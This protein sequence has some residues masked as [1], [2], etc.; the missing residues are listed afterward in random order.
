MKSGSDDRGP[1]ERM[2]RAVGII[3]IAAALA[4]A[5]AVT[6]FVVSQLTGCADPVSVPVNQ[7]CPPK[8]RCLFDSTGAPVVIRY[9]DFTPTQWHVGDT[10]G[11]DG[12]TR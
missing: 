11:C 5:V 2:F 6:V 7:P 1:A 4:A 10:C 8:R 9:G 3:L 12:P